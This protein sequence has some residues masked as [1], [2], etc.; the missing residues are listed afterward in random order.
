MRLSGY[1]ALI[2]EATRAAEELPEDARGLLGAMLEGCAAEA[3]AMERLLLPDV[4]AALP[5][6]CVSLAA[7]RMRRAAG[8]LA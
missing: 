5:E 7:A 6:N 8:S 2:A 3:R 4:P 1:M